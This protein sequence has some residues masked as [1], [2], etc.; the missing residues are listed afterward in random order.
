MP[1]RS[2][3][4]C[5]GRVDPRRGTAAPRMPSPVTIVVGVHEAL[6]A[7]KRR[8]VT[9]DDDRRVRRELPAMRH[10]SRTLPTFTM[11]EEMPTMSYGGRAVLARSARAWENPARC[12]GARCSPGSS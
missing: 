8:H 7:G 1:E 6:D 5:I 9:S 2:P 3:G 4:A 11:I 10:I 12:D